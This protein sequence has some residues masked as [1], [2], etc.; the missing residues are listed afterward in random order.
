[1]PIAEWLRMLALTVPLGLGVHLLGWQT[2][3]DA[4]PKL[5]F[6]AIAGT[7][8]VFWLY[9]VAL[10][11]NHEVKRNCPTILQCGPKR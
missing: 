9:S 6:R 10:T 4:K 3:Y 11:I 8:L 5:L 1:M 7:L 2:V